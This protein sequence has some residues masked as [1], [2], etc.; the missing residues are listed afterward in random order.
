[1][2]SIVCY[3]L[4]WCGMTYFE[5]V[6]LFGHAALALL[7]LLLISM[8]PERLRRFFLRDDRLLHRMIWLAVPAC[9]VLLLHYYRWRGNHELLLEGL[10]VFLL[11]LLGALYWRRFSHAL[12]WYLGGL[13]TVAGAVALWT[14][15]KRGV[16]HGLSG[17][18]NWSATLVVAGLAALSFLLLRRRL[19]PGVLLGLVIVL[20]PRQDFL[21]RGM[22]AALVGGVLVAGFLRYRSKPAT[23]WLGCLC[24]V[25]LLGGV[26]LLVRSDDGIRNGL[27]QGAVALTCA[28]PVLGVGP[29]RFAG[30]I[31]PYLPDVYHQSVF[32]TEFNPHPHNE[33]LR[34]AAEFGLPGVLW[35]AAVLLAAGSA[36]FKVRRTPVGRSEPGRIGA[37]LFLFTLVGL[38]GQ[39]DVL[40]SQWPLDTFFWV[41]AGVFWG[42]ASG[43]VACRAAVRE[44]TETP[45]KQESTVYWPLR[46]VQVV[47]AVFLLVFLVRSAGSGWHARAALLAGERGEREAAAVAWNAARKWKTDARN[48]YAGAAEALFDRKDPEAALLFLDRLQLESAAGNYLHC[49]G[50]RARALAVQGK[51]EESLP[52]F[53]AEQRN[54]PYGAVNLDQWRQVLEALGRRE[55]A[56]K[57]RMRRDEVMR[58]KGLPLSFL[59]QLRRHPE[60]DVNV[61]RIPREMLEGGQ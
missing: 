1:M 36:L 52:F 25:V 55:E 45:E 17:N 44:E 13:G 35:W 27:A 60:W 30:E 20:L 2:A 15:W 56:A 34:F 38:H 14:A 12:L 59:S 23:I 54:Y 47:L 53:E 51:L 43:P 49:Q 22:L 7:A 18:W 61:H 32:A 39:F 26:V 58:R 48:L 24:G 5:E 41:C 21:P 40:L 33:I 6:R 57:I 11:V 16:P 10:Y 9:V 50:L 19:W 8:E 3:P 37:L 31:R 28:H 42:Y 4:L 29:G 46:A